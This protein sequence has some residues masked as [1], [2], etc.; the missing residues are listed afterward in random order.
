MKNEILGIK[1]ALSTLD[2][3]EPEAYKEEINE[4]L[5]CI[6]HS[7]KYDEAPLLSG[8]DLICVLEHLGYD[9]TNHVDQ[10]DY[11]MGLLRDYITK[12]IEIDEVREE[13]LRG[14]IRKILL[15]I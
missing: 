10:V 7:K 3:Y 11:P 9:Q 5:D 6:L 13:Y 1:L 8:D 4:I 14:K 2:F 15:G 12:S